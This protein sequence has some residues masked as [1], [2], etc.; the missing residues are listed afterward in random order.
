MGWFIENYQGIEL[1][2]HDGDVLGFKSLL[3]FIP[4]ADVGLVL[5][6][7]RTI[8]FGFSTTIRYRLVEALYG[9]DVEAGEYYKAQWDN[10]METIPQLRAP[11]EATLPPAEVA[12]YL[13]QYSEGWQVEQRGDG[14]LWAI[15]G[16]YEWQLLAQEKG[17]FMVSNGFGITTPLEF[18]QDDQGNMSMVFTLST[19]ERGE[20]R[21]LNQ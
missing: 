13:G 6:T 15:R 14:T 11:L 20:Y 9:L 7:N 21:R 4:E 3:A 19:G 16:Q 17:K 5:L 8:S 18:T 12:L 10:F 2:W 1:I